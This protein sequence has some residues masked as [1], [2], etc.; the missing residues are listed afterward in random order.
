MVILGLRKDPIQK[1][2]TKGGCEKNMRVPLSIT[3]S[4]ILN[5]TLWWRTKLTCGEGS[6]LQGSWF[7]SWYSALQNQCPHITGNFFMAVN[8]IEQM[9]ILLGA[10]K[11]L[12]N[13]SA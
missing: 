6:R 7:P 2:F 1:T 10:Q 9:E 8:V 11:N 12:K 4:V 13:W 5:D 3:T